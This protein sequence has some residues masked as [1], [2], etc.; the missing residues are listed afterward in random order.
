[1][2][3]EVYVITSRDGAAYTTVHASREVV[4]SHFDDYLTE[5]PEAA[6]HIIDALD[7]ADAGEVGDLGDGDRIQKLPIGGLT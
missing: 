7:A 5:T 2:N 1:M 4:L 3:A 6:P